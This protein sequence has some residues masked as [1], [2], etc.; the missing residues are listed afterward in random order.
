[1]I[2]VL[3]LYGYLQDGGKKFSNGWT[4]IKPDCQNVQCIY[5]H[6]FVANL[7]VCTNIHGCHLLRKD[8][9]I[10]YVGIQFHYIKGHWQILLESVHG[11]P[12]ASASM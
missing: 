6:R 1:M 11:T 5:K 10:K 2:N 8:H 9:N 7:Q 12:R 3:I 4:C